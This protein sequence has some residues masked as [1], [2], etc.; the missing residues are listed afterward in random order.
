[1]VEKKRIILVNPPVLAVLEPWYDSPK[2]VR[3]ALACLAGYLRA[4][5][6][7]EVKCLDAKFDGKNFDQTV[8]EIIAWNPTIVGLTAFTNE[9]KPAAYLAGLI[10]KANPNII[11][12]C[13]GAH[14]TAI[15][16]QTLTE[17]PTF[18]IGVIGEGEETLLELCDAISSG[19]DLR[20][21]AGLIF[22]PAAGEILKTRA[23]HRILDQEALPMPAWDLLPA[24]S[25]YY[26]Q[27]IR[28]CPFNCYFCMNHNGKVARKRAVD[29]VIEE[30][31]WLIESFEAKRISFGDELFS[32]DMARTEELLDAM[33]ANRIG[34]SVSWDIQTHVA[35]VNDNLLSKMKAANLDKIEMGV[36]S[37]DEITLKRMGKGTNE[38]MIVNAFKM[39]HK[40]GLKTGAFFII[41]QP[42]ETHKTI[43]NSLRLAIKIN[44]TEPIFGTMVPYPGTEI[45]RMAAAGEGGYKLLTTDWD[46]YSIQLN[47][48]MQIVSMSQ[49]MLE[50]YQILA[51]TIV[52]IGNF[53]IMDFIRFVYSYREGAINLL[54]KIFSG[55]E[56]TAGLINFPKDYDLVLN[57]PV[58]ITMDELIVA[59]DNWKDIQSAEVK[60]AKENKPELL[61]T[62]MPV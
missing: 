58:Q 31:K 34:Q 11:T 51:Y 32:V 55:S 18:D 7:W 38:K 30:M 37:G 52:F 2:F 49:T 9:I 60:F 54:K 10:K 26:I 22:R 25:E 36:E 21:V 17:F 27:S 44:P 8:S 33:I 41:G 24:A 47:S 39:A 6:D 28:G 61:K 16:E 23:R 13:G 62:Q 20:E 5:S 57:S 15:P 53:R 29:Q 42:N 35:Y 4:H 48:S 1:M 19:R 46:R 50:L 45:S 59:R 40:N 56:G 43:W 12:V 14:L 3:T